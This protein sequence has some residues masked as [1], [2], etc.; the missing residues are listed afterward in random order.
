VNDAE[1]LRLVVFDATQLSRPPRALGASWHAGALLYK[2]M[3]WVD[4]TYGARSVGDALDWVLRTARERPIREL[5]YWGHGKWG[6]I[7][8]D[9]ES[10]D[11]GSLAKGHALRPK[12]EALRE[13][14]SPAALL[15]FRT[16]ETLGACAGQD[17]ARALGDFTGASVA[18]HTF[19]IGYFQSGLHVLAPGASPSWPETEGLREG[20]PEDPRT[21]FESGP[22]QPNTVTCFTH[23]VPAS[24][25]GERS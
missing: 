3:G 5:Q 21:A 19:V 16:C 13:R 7:L 1:P 9:R 20:T 4:A 24:C 6:R 22:A 11:R 18:G 15:W 8:I 14:L 2:G 10:F 12:L 23:A 17:F 25:V